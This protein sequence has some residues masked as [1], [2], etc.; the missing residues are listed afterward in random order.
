MSQDAA[1]AIA[2]IVTRVKDA[3]IRRLLAEGIHPA[4]I[5][6]FRDA[7]TEEHGVLVE[8]ERALVI[9]VTIKDGSA[10]IAPRWVGDFERLNTLPEAG[11]MLSN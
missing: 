4:R 2:S 8:M 3:G 5:A 7:A 11:L 10:Y 9:A 6:S 1:E